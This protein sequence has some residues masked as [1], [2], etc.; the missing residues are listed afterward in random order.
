M[1]LRYKRML[2]A[3]EKGK[4]GEMKTKKIIIEIRNTKCRLTLHLN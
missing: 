3:E 1:P 2:D 4:W